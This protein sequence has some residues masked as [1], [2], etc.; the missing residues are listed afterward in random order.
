MEN[1][2][3]VA[4]KTKEK[5][6]KIDKIDKKY[7]WDLTDIYKT[8]EDYEKDLKKVLSLADEIE[9][10]EGKLKD[11]KYLM[12]CFALEKE[13]SMLE[14]KLSS[15]AFLSSSI[16]L[17]DEE[18]KKRLNQLDIVDNKISEKTVYIMPE[19]SNIDDEVLKKYMEDEDFKNYKFTFE[20]IIENKKHIYSKE[21]E[22]IIDYANEGK[23]ELLDAYNFLTELEMP[24]DNAIDKNGKEYE[25]TNSKY[26]SYLESKDETLR[27]TAMFS[28]LNSYKKFN[29]TLSSTYIGLLKSMSKSMKYRKYDGVLE[30]KLK[31]EDLNTNIY[32]ALM[33]GVRDNLDIVNKYRRLNYELFKKMGITKEGKRIKPWDGALKVLEKDHEK[34]EYE[35]AKKMVLEG[36]SILGDEYIKNL[37]Y[38]FENRYIDVFPRKGKESGGYNLDI[39]DV[40]PYILLN[41]DKT[42]DDVTT[43]AHELGHSM[44]GI[45][46]RKQDYTLYGYNIMLAETASTT[47]EII[48]AEYLISIEKD[49]KKKAQ[50]LINLI[51]TILN[52]I[53]LQAMFGSFEERAF[54]MAENEEV[55]TPEVLN[56]LYEDLEKEFYPSI[57]KDKDKINETKEEK[58]EIKKIKELKKYSWTRVPHFYRPFYVYKYSVGMTAAI[59]IYLNILEETQ[60][61]GQNKVNNKIDEQN[62]EKYINKYF[63]MLKSGG[64]KK[65]L[66]TFKIAKIDLEDKK[67]YKKAFMFLN[68]KID[69]LK[70]IIDEI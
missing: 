48:M 46:A 18:V 37:E 45:F 70:N 23:G 26:S 19:L 58:E 67:I 69:E 65:I 32:K 43:I 39:Y 21:I 5:E 60:K 33:D 61:N 44:H 3:K 54:K 57:Y 64:S 16:N 9:K 35:D 38:I 2:K 40:H 28:R 53:V 49:K 20:K 50:K 36:L 59:N 27:K 6:E 10:L 14:D 52:T 8:N 51:D 31:N 4:K 29:N 30:S 13:M 47:N 62:N 25:V 42:F 56:K 11:K 41:Y 55:I 17:D 66:D 68:N 15:Y 63:N 24:F 7:T 12:K 22:Q 34:I 1:N